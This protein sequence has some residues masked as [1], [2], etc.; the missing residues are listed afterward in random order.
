MTGYRITAR[1]LDG[2]DL[3]EEILRE[4]TDL[5]TFEAIEPATLDLPAEKVVLVLEDEDA[6]L[7][8]PVAHGG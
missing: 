2:Q 5:E 1:S 4:F 7:E 3:S 8:G 6:I